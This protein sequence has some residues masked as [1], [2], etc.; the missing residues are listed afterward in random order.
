MGVEVRTLRGDE[1]EQFLRFLERS[2]GH[3]FN[4]FPRIHPDLYHPSGL[5]AFLVAVE[6]GRIVSHVGTFPMRVVAGRAVIEFG[7]IGGVATLPD[8]RGRGYMSR[9]LQESLRRMRERGVQASILW[10]DRRRY[11]NFGFE[12]CGVGYEVT[13]TLRSLEGAGVQALPVE[14]ADPASPATVAHVQ[15]FQALRAFRVERPRLDL[16][17][18]RHGVR[19]FVCDDGYLLAQHEARDL[20]VQEVVSASGNE[21]GLVFGALRHT[22]GSRATLMAGPEDDPAVRRLAAAA[23]GWRAVPQGMITVVDWPALAAALR[24]VLEERAAPLKPFSVVIGC[25]SA[26]GVDWATL[27]WAGSSLDVLPGRKGDAE[28]VLEAG[29]L[30]AALFGGPYSKERLGPLAALTPV[31]FHVP[32]LDHV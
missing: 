12:T 7:G 8:A 20:D 9:L 11:R 15:R 5:D 25:R 24:P 13:L 30:V 22:F 14:E 1:F 6:D 4:F 31:P 32:R 29:E 16:T 17:L 19:V 18:A 2:Y 23:H 26:D 21:A 28:C 10:G 27:R 3:S